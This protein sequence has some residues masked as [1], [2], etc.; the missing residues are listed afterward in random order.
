MIYMLVGLIT[1]DDG[2]MILI[3]RIYILNLTQNNISF[4]LNNN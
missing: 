4:T 3:K 1:F 2:L